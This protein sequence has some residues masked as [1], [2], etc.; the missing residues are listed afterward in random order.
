MEIYSNERITYCNLDLLYN[1]YEINEN[2]LL[3]VI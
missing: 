3:I 1:Y 2:E